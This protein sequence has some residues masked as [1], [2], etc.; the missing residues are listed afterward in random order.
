MDHK[1]FINYLK[2]LE[3]EFEFEFTDKRIAGWYKRFNDV[4]EEVFDRAI[5]YVLDNCKHKPQRSHLV[6]GIQE[7]KE[8]LLEERRYTYVPEEDADEP[9]KRNP[10]FRLED[11]LGDNI[12]WRR[13]AE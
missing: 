11:V 6:E 1:I 2:K 8:Q 4:K 13:K 5:E 10:N 3:D 12:P 7:A 9:P